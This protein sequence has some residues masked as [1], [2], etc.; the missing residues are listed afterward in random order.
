MSLL[1][2]FRTVAPEAQFSVQSEYPPLWRDQM[3]S[4]HERAVPP[5]PRK[6]RPREMLDMLGVDPESIIA[7]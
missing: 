5:I 1:E 7:L 4:I 6:Y 3:A 2:Q